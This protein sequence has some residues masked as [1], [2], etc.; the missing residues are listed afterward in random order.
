M[1]DS[2]GVTACVYCKLYSYLSY[3]CNLVYFL[4]LTFNLIDITFTWFLSCHKLPLII[5]HGPFSNLFCICVVIDPFP[6][7]VTTH[8]LG[9]PW[10]IRSLSVGAKLN[11]Q[12]SDY[13]NGDVTK[14]LPHCH[15]VLQLFYHPYPLFLTILRH[16][17][18]GLSTRNASFL[19]DRG[20][21]HAS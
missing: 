1:V 11:L 10:K 15:S 12:Y 19:R 17:I 13:M 5:H 9:T 18:Y 3:L 14:F 16:F 20:S 8:Y 7:Y 2:D 21:I 6:I 4:F